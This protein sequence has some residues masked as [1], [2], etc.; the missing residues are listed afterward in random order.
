MVRSALCGRNHDA[1]PGRSISTGWHCGNLRYEHVSGWRPDPQRTPSRVDGRPSPPVHPVHRRSDRRSEQRR[2]DPPAPPRPRGRRTRRHNRARPRSG[3]TRAR[4]R[5]GSRARRARVVSR[6]C[7][8]S[9]RRGPFGACSATRRCRGGWPGPTPNGSPRSSPRSFGDGGEPD[10][11][12]VSSLAGWRALTPELQAPHR[13][14]SHRS[15]DGLP[16]RAA[17]DRRSPLVAVAPPATSRHAAARATAG[18]VVDS[19][20]DRRVGPRRGSSSDGWRDRAGWSSRATRTSCPRR[21]RRRS[22]RSSPTASPHRRTV[23]R[24]GAGRSGCCSRPASSTSRTSTAPSGSSAACCRRSGAPSDRA[25]SSWRVRTRAGFEQQARDAGRHGDGVGARHGR[26]LRTRHR[27]DRPAP[28]RLGHPGQDPRGVVV[29]RAGDR[30]SARS[31]RVGRPRRSRAPARAHT[32]R[33]GRRR[34]AG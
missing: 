25:T 11:L 4:V 21:G 20:V 34:V 14:R 31:G 23:S 7:R 26:A 2:G 19:E 15:S 8:R 17:P 1:D 29:G 24:R 33:S 30:H 13:V 9:R 18:R 32:R 3:G 28:R 6:R 10:L 16:R 27:S 12:W 5:A 22:S